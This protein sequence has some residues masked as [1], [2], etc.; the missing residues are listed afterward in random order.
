MQQ[1][2]LFRECMIKEGCGSET[3]QKHYQL[4]RQTRDKLDQLRMKTL[5]KMENII[6]RDKM[7]KILGQAEE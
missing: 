1:R 6:G 7:K 3:T 2:D 4:M 5:V